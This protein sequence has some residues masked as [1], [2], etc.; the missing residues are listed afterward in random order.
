MQYKLPR[1]EM[2]TCHASKAPRLNKHKQI[3]QT[4][5]IVCLFVKLQHKNNQ[6]RPIPGQAGGPPIRLYSHLV[7]GSVAIGALTSRLS[8]FDAAFAFSFSFA[9]AFALALALPL[10]LPLPLSLPCLCLAFAFALPCLA[11]A[12]ALPWLPWLP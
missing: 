12:F 3:T 10:P 4:Q 2:C 1:W 5:L 11:F 6:V 7:R 9:F 8:A